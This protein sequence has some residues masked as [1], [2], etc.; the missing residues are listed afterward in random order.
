MLD[1]DE[2]IKKDLQKMK[3]TVLNDYQYYDR[4][5]DTVSM[6]F[7]GFGLYGSFEMLKWY[8]TVDYSYSYLLAIPI[9]LWLF[10]LFMSLHNITREKKIRENYMQQIISIPKPKGKELETLRKENID[11]EDDLTNSRRWT[12]RLSIVG[13]VL[14]LG[15]LVCFL[16]G[17]L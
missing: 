14:M 9:V 5:Y 16:T 10:I 2:E 3:E 13:V 17:N 4:R 11:L 1:S 7:A 6:I 8:L 12:F 15:S